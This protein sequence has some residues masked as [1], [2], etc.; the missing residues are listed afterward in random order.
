MR[1]DKTIFSDDVY[2]WLL[3]SGSTPCTLYGLPK[4]LKDGCPIR[5]FLSAIGTF[6]YN[7]AK[8]SVPILDPLTNNKYTV[9]KKS[10]KFIKEI[11]NTK[12][13]INLLWPVLILNFYLS[14]YL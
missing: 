11:L 4:I 3:A 14:T 6:N 13:L 2:N 7:L 8:F 9:K 10:V 5:P 12:F 1:T